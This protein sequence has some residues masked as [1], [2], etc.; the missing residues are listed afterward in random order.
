[1][2]MY[3]KNIK[4]KNKIKN[5]KL[6]NNIHKS[7]YNIKK[8]YIV[9]QNLNNSNVYSNTIKICQKN[10]LDKKRMSIIKLFG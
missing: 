10:H 2:Y 6:Q 3:I 1:M 4:G 7:L 9:I 5:I 8:Q